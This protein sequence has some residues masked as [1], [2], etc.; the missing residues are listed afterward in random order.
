MSLADPWR[1]AV[2]TLTVWR[3]RAPAQVD[4][5]I[6]A[7]AMLLA[8]LAVLPLGVVAGLV[9]WIGTRLGLPDLLLGLL[10]VGALA[11]GTR[12]MHWDG[13]SDLADGLTASYDRER[14]LAVMKTGTSG[15]AGGI[16]LL[17]VAGVQAVGFAA[18]PADGWGAVLAGVVV[19][20]SRGSLA[21]CCLRGVP[22]AR[23]DGLG[24]AFAG[25]VSRAAGLLLWAVVVAAL[26]AAAAAAGLGW[27]PALAAGGLALM[28]VGA[29]LV[30]VGRRL[31][32]VT[33]DVFGAA[34][35]LVLAALLVGLLMSPA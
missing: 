3:V 22:S 12:V 15:P 26:V 6:A 5:R 27:W 33:G 1:L 11:L 32:G 18:L 17:V 35:E 14:A 16:A 28:V 7:A 20:A 23:P 34:I 10:V 25:S 29:L 30:H 31:G 2:G 9:V 8:P 4:R 24:G 19:C 13:L 21:L